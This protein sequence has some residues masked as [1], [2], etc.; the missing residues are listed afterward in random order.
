[1]REEFGFKI[2]GVPVLLSFSELD[3]AMQDRFKYEIVHI[4]SR[5]CQIFDLRQHGTGSYLG[6]MTVA[7]A[8]KKFG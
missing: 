8:V 7:D 4:D 5:I 2:A 6:K 1:M 3:A